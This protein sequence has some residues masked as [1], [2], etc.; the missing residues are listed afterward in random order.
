MLPHWNQ[1]ILIPHGR[2]VRS[3]YPVTFEYARAMMMMYVPWSNKKH[4]DFSDRLKTVKE[5]EHLV[6]AKQ[7]PTAATAQYT[8]A[9]FYHKIKRI[10]VT[11]KKMVPIEID[12]DEDEDE[13]SDYRIY[14]RAMNHFTNDKPIPCIIGDMSFNVGTDRDWTQSSSLHIKRNVTL[15]GNYY[16]EWIKKK[17]TQA[18]SPNDDTEVNDMQ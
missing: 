15:P 6:R 10:E 1:K 13:Y 12:Q 17:Y 11:A 5:Y 18:Y 16:V 14:A 4:L 2:N 9:K 3:V 7:L 8:R